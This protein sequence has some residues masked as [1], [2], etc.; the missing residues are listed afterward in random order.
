MKHLLPLA[1]V[2]SIALYFSCTKDKAKM[3]SVINC[4]TVDSA[5]NTY[6]V[7]V[8]AILDG[9]CTAGCH[10]QFVQNRGLR[11][12]TY[13]NAKSAFQN[14][15][16]QCALEHLN[17]CVPMPYQSAKLADSSIA[18]LECWANRGYPQ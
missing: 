4:T 10:D 8:K 12:D 13:D 9:Y 17:G 18:Q 7:Q 2:L 11:Y 6:N 5:T 14:T 15:N 1:T 3:Q 16:V